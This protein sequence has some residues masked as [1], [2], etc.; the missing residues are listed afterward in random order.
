MGSTEPPLDPPQCFNALFSRSSSAIRRVFAS[1][2]SSRFAILLRMVFKS[3]LLLNCTEQ[4]TLEGS[5][6]ERR[7]F[8]SLIPVFLA[9]K[10]GRDIFKKTI[11]LQIYFTNGK[12]SKSRPIS[13]QSCTLFHRLKVLLKLGTHYTCL[14]EIL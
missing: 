13:R 11:T 2:V 8:F 1:Y 7:R 9:A 10:C 3:V 6:L 4:S 14:T 5:G 12:L